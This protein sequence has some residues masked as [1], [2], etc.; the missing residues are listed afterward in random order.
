MSRAMDRARMESP[1]VAGDRQETRAPSGIFRARRETPGRALR[2]RNGS[3]GRNR[4]RLL[5]PGRTAAPGRGSLAL[6]PPGP[7]AVRNLPVRGTWLSTLRAPAQAPKELAPRAT[8]GPAWSGC[9]VQG[10]ANSPPSATG[11]GDGS[12]APLLF[13]LRD[14]RHNLEEG[15]AGC[16]VLPT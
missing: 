6:L 4:R 15:G 3:P 11:R 16:H 5:E 12:R 8:F 1:R 2:R 7:D 10:T 9:R 14:N 13:R